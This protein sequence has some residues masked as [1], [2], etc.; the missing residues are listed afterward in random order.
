MKWHKSLLFVLIFTHF[1]FSVE[2]VEVDMKMKKVMRFANKQLKKHHGFTFINKTATIQFSFIF[3]DK[4][5]VMDVANVK[6]KDLPP[7]IQRYIIREVKKLKF[8]RKIGDA[9]K[10][11]YSAKMETWKNDWRGALMIPVFSQSFFGLRFQF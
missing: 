10:Y 3:D 1:S 7:N 11:T 9:N 4:G 8:Y 5:Y 6:S 2:K